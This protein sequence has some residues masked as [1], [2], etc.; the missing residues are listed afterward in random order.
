MD[1]GCIICRSIIPFKDSMW[2]KYLYKHSNVLSTCDYF[3]TLS[4]L[5]NLCLF[6]FIYN[7]Q[8]SC[9]KSSFCIW[10]DT[11]PPQLNRSKNTAKVVV[12][13]T[14]VFRTAMCL[15][16]SSVPILFSTQ[17]EELIILIGWVLIIGFIIYCSYC[18]KMYL[19][20]NS[21]LKL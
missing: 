18:C 6:A 15:I 8:P 7:R 1:C 21:C 11:K 17:T 13:L 5:F 20:I 3:W 2:R 19:L 10:G 16:T 12:R 14:V 9:G 4:I